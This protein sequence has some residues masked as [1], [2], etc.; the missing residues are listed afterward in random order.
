MKGLFVN[1]T[2][3]FS[4]AGIMDAH[5]RSPGARQR[6]F[7]ILDAWIPPLVPDSSKAYDHIL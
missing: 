6:E 4:F 2:I 5:E 1:F 7:W 3:D